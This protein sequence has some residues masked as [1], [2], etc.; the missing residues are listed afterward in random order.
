MKGTAIIDYGV[1]N[2]FSLK[3]SFAAIGETAF[4]TTDKK[5]L[6]S[7]DRV[8]LPG[9]GAFS[10]AAEKL[11]QSGMDKSLFKCAENGTPVLGICLGMQLLFE[12]SFEYG[13]HDGLKLINGEIL[14]L[15]RFGNATVNAFL[16]VCFLE[17]DVRKSAE[18]LQCIFV[19]IRL[20]KFRNVFLETVGEKLV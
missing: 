7:A 6:E 18:I 9:V 11:R 13:V 3:S 20:L 14:I 15:C 2:L 16:D 4:V 10:D 17:I 19:K 12:R 8:V 1:G 5:E